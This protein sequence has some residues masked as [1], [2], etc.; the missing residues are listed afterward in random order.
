VKKSL[1]H[2]GGGSTGGWSVRLVSVRVPFARRLPPFSLA[3]PTNA[4]S[5]ALPFQPKATPLSLDPVNLK[6][7]PPFSDPDVVEARH[8]VGRRVDG[9][10]GGERGPRL[11]HAA[12]DERGLA[13]LGEGEGAVVRRRE[14]CVSRRRRQDQGA[15]HG[16]ER[17]SRVVRHATAAPVKILTIR[18]THPHVQPPQQGS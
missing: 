5:E 3:L 8:A 11:H 14:V 10:G 12:R 6:R 2:V 7:V 15:E 13:L 18:S 17:R 9:D 1:L 4:V 16:E